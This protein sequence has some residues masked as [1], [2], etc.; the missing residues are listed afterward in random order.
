MQEF[1]YQNLLLILI[2]AVVIGMIL[3][4]KITLDIREG[5]RGRRRHRHG[6]R[7]YRRNRRDD[8]HYDDRDHDRD[9][10]DDYYRDRDDGYISRLF[11]FLVLLALIV[12]GGKYLVNSGWLK[13]Q[14]NQEKNN[15]VGQKTSQ[16]I[17]KEKKKQNQAGIEVS[18]EDEIPSFVRK[19][20]IPAEVETGYYVVASY[21]FSGPA[22]DLRDE[23]LSQNKDVRYEEIEDDSNPVYKVYI[24]PFADKKEAN[25][26]IRKFHLLDN[27]EIIRH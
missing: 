5:R 18:E 3:G 26:I 13:T 1:I 20:D 8:D 12:G 4:G 24:G 22:K 14:E 17:E 6:H 15:Q 2:G 23:L 9:D 21:S 16:G 19:E 7:N 10:E 11:A 25:A 27:A